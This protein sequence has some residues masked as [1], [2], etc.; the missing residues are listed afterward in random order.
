MAR[1]AAQG[2]PRKVPRTEGASNEEP[3]GL[4]CTKL[5]GEV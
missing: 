2:A 4:A 5:A 1:L 3:F